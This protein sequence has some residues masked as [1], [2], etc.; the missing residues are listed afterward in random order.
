MRARP[1]DQYYMTTVKI[2]PKGQIVIPKEAREMFGLAPGDTVVLM[3]DKKR[4]IALQTSAALRGV[5][6]RI[7]NGESHVGNGAV[8]HTGVGVRQQAQI[9]VVEVDA[10]GKPYIL[11]C[12]AK[13]PHIF[14]RT[15]AFPL[16]HIIFLILRLAKMGMETHP[17]LPGHD[18]ALPQQLRRD[19]ERRTGCQH[20][21]M[22][23]AHRRI[24]ILFNE[25][26]AVAHDLIHCLHHAVRRQAAIFFA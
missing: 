2:G 17:I 4:G 24:M 25:A 16:E 9:L 10:V 1:N 3:A 15:Y 14:Q 12:P 18:G 5:V 20:D 7:F 26:R 23:G 8:S 22:H 6:K 13:T 19:G 11:A 21:L